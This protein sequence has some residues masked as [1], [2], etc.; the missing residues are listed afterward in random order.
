MPIS[1]YLEA[2]SVIRAVGSVTGKSV[3]DYA[4][5]DGFFARV[6]KS[7]GADIVVCVD[8]LPEM[9]ELARQKEERSPLGITYFIHDASIIKQIGNFDLATAIFLFNYA[10]DTD[11][12]SKMIENIGSNL[13]SNGRLVA[14]VPNPSFIT[15][16]DD[17]LPYGYFVEEIYSDASRVKV[18]MT[19]TGDKVFS[20]QFTQWQKH[21]Y[22]DLL[23]K[24]GFKN[25]SWTKYTVSD[26]GIKLLGKDF[27]RT[28][29]ENSKSM[30][31]SASKI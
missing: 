19:F 22:E 11:T 4:C 21:I 16:R 31:L 2:L 28:A 8:L 1:D 17:T 15:D 13:I 18:K 3:I 24:A 6:W 27:W 10:E 29:L 25:I 12:L 23:I 14:A 9:I 30:I 26:E 7:F 20:I 5:G